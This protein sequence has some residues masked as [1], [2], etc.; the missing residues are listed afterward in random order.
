MNVI[1]QK[2]DI[3]PF[4]SFKNRPIKTELNLNNS[5]NFN[6]LCK[7]LKALECTHCLIEEEYL[8]MS[9]LYDYTHYYAA[10]TH[11]YDKYTERVHFFKV[12]A[13]TTFEKST[14]YEKYITG[15]EQFP[16]YLGHTILKPLYDPNSIL[17]VT[18]LKT[19]PINPYSNS[20]EIRKYPCVRNYKVNLFGKTLEIETLIS[21]SQDAVSAC[22]STALFSTTHLLADIYKTEKLFPSQITKLAHQ[23]NPN[24]QRVLPNRNGLDSKQ[25][26]SIFRHLKLTHEY[27]PMSNKDKITTPLSR[28]ELFKGLVYAYNYAKIPV[29]VMVERFNHIPNT[30]TEEETPE[31][32]LV[33]NTGFKLDYTLTQDKGLKLFSNNLSRCYWIDDNY[34]PQSNVEIGTTTS[35][36]DFQ[37]KG[38]FNN[39]IKSCYDK[40]Y[41]VIIPLEKGVIIDYD[42]ILRHITKMSEILIDFKIQHNETELSELNKFPEWEIF[43][44]LSNEYKSQVVQYQDI[45]DSEQEKLLFS[46]LSKYVWVARLVVKKLLVNGD[47]EAEIFMEFVFDSTVS[48]DTPNF[49]RAILFNKSFTTEIKSELKSKIE[50]EL[51]TKTKD[52]YFKNTMDMPQLMIKYLSGKFI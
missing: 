8:S 36:Y 41:A 40:L 16:E 22:A 37:T 19:Y 28:L 25:V 27:I 26:V 2:M 47:E 3:I 18:M 44:T 52:T 48:P 11:K 43:L 38:D 6:Y 24:N 5:Q 50:D 30:T 12:E 29:L 34:G 14:F 1:S 17:G 33:L 9:F 32:H 35:S 21:Q 4:E 51:S 49:C 10:Q 45:N 13:S 39:N 42:T 46:C 7:Y 15:N 23:Y 20:Q 31:L